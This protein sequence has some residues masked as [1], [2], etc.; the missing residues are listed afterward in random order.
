MAQGSLRGGNGAG[1]GHLGHAAA[2]GGGGTGG[3]AKPLHDP[4]LF[5]QRGIG[6]QQLEGE[7]VQLGLGLWW[8]ALAVVLMVIPAVTALMLCAA[9]Q[10]CL[11][12]GRAGAVRAGRFVGAALSR[13]GGRL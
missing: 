4:R 6:H 10:A 11:A 1:I 9:E 7:A 2:F 13:A 5:L 8:N 3:L 12:W